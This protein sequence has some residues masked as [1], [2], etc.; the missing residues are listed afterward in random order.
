MNR[1]PRLDLEFEAIVQLKIQSEFIT[2]E[3]ALSRKRHS[4]DITSMT[5]HGM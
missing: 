4:A 5:R 1:W 3:H 2:H